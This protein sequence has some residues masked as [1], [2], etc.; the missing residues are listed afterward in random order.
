LLAQ[1]C[2]TTIERAGGI[3]VLIPPRVDADARMAAA[4]IS[5][6]DE[7]MVAGGVDVEPG[8]Y[9][10]RPDPACIRPVPIV[11]PLSWPWP[12]PQASW[13]HRCWAYAAGCG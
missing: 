6:L 13:T 3:A 1:E 9:A 7:L 4:V 2:V 8:R 11:T 10:A 12:A 5:R